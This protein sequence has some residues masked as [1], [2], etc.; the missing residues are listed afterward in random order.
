MDTQIQNLLNQAD[1]LQKKL[2]SFRPMDEI[3]LK[4]LRDYY[5]VG[6]TYSS[7]ALEGNSLT[8]SETKVVIEDGLTIEGKPLREIYEA[9][10]HAKA[11]DYM[12]QLAIDEPLSE[13]VICQLHKLFYQ[14]IDEENAGKYRKVPVFISGSK[15]GVAQVDKIETEVKKLV[16]W[17]NKN[18]QKLHPIVLA[19]H[20]HKRFVF[21]HP[22]VD[23]NGR[24]ARLL[25]NLAL[26][27]NEFN[28]ALIPSILRA[29]YVYSLEKA[30]TDDTPF[31]QFII[32]RV[33]ATQQ[34][35]IRLL[36]GV[37][38]DNG[39]VNGGVMDLGEKI[40]EL[41]KNTPRI[42]APFIA[43]HL[44]CSLR[45]TQRYLKKLTE[46][47]RIEYRGAARNGGYEL[48]K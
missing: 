40:I 39:G 1:E 43:E 32:E 33:I 45:T 31:L 15:Y 38:T 21:I 10:G 20:L 24:V 30:H 27:R 2:L 6:L 23:G 11:Y 3:S 16:E 41:L 35:L 29:E 12:Q 46:E 25:M 34:D 7:N 18:E 4:S 13:E 9:T 5:R 44:N 28:I 14:Q 48:I 42:R 36:G 37:N 22:F 26:I 17:Y 19:A 47:G 8:E